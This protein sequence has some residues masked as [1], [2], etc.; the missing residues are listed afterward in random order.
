MRAQLYAVA[1]VWTSKATYPSKASALKLPGPDGEW[2]VVQR[3]L[4]S[5]R[6]FRIYSPTSAAP[7]KSVSGVA[8]ALFSGEM[9]RQAQVKFNLATRPRFAPR[10][11]ETV[12]EQD[13]VEVEVM[14]V[15]EVESAL[16]VVE[17][18]ELTDGQLDRIMRVLDKRQRTADAQ[19][20]DKAEQ[21]VESALDVVESNELTGGQLDRILRVVKRQRTAYAKKELQSQIARDEAAVDHKRRRLASLD[22][23]DEHWGLASMSGARSSAM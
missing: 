20:V 14:E 18:N 21:G 22:S 10:A 19:E 8:N 4:Q 16:A 11:L 3:C 9:L 6:D 7:F 2:L 12:D 15:D 13:E 23:E 5:C 17:S 1:N